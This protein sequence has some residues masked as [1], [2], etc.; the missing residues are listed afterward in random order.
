MR[1]TLA[2]TLASLLWAPALDSQAPPPTGL[3]AGIVVAEEPGEPPLRRVT[4]HLSG[5]SLTTARIVL[6][7]DQGR[8][9]FDRLPAGRY[10]LTATRPGFVRA[11]FG[12]ARGRLS[13]GRPVS[14]ADGQRLADLTLRMMRGGV[15]TGLLT[16]R[17]GRPAAGAGVQIG[18]LRER[19]GVLTMTS[20]GGRAVVADDRGIYRAYGLAP[21]RFVV[22]AH[23]GFADRRTIESPTPD[24]GPYLGYVP[25]YYPG[26]PDPSAAVVVEVGAGEERAGLDFVIRPARMSRVSGTVRG[27]DGEPVRARVATM[28]AG[29][30]LAITG[31]GNAFSA[32]T[33]T[34]SSGAFTLTNRPP[35]RHALLAYV[36]GRAAQWA[37]TSFT[38]DGGDLSGLEIQLQPAP[39][40]SGRLVVAGAEPGPLPDAL[41]GSRI[42][43][44]MGPG[45]LVAAGTGPSP[46][47]RDGTFTI[48]QMVGGTYVLSVQTPNATADPPWVVESAMLGGVDLTRRWLTLDSGTPDGLVITMTDQV[49]EIRGRLTDQSGNPASAYVLLA[50]PAEP[51]M[52][53]MGAS[54]LH[55]PA[56]PAP[57]GS[58]RIGG[59][60]AGDYYLAA[61]TDLAR[62]DH[63]DPDFLEQLVPGAIRLSLA[64]GETN[65]QDIRIARLTRDPA[66]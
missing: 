35:G 1:R 19:D 16:D 51:A 23:L 15:L 48:Q 26:T 45:T 14:L 32:S 24:D 5:D 37:R 30:S 10:T 63:L 21:G 22:A 7:D 11:A 56:Y 4:V 41:T 50:F 66:D 49:A 29:D 59:L 20:A 38:T 64:R 62:A 43:L 9:A 42:R 27:V 8:F 39:L 57:D 34:D 31:L 46:V 61:V 25:T 60:A 33:L 44:Q 13:S 6:T 36:P 18:E 58:Y 2:V 52:W 12:G 28:P 65:V 17:H 55:E 47:A 53:R 40:V 54:R 3:V